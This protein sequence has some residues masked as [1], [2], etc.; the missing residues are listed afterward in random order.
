MG[1][2][3][4]GLV[5]RAEVRSQKGPRKG[6]RQCEEMVV[7]L[8]EPEC[9]YCEGKYIQSE[10]VLDTWFSALWPFAGLSKED[11]EKY[12][13]GNVL[14]TARDIINLTGRADDLLRLRIQEKGSLH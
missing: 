7:S 3:V 2:P 14:V 10:D 4:A 1:T 9:K 6:F 5:S 12:Y 13:P 11:A 8:T